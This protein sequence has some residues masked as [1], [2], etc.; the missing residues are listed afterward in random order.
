M[1]FTKQHSLQNFT[2][3]SFTFSALFELVPM[4]DIRLLVS[5]A[6]Y[7]VC[8]PSTLPILSKSQRDDEFQLYV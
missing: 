1:C 2:F 4:A 3:F 7:H 5:A 6:V 8:G